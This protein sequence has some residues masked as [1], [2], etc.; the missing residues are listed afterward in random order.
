MSEP[1][2]HHIIPQMLLKNFCY[3]DKLC[4]YNKELKSYRHNQ[5]IKNVC[6]QSYYYGNDPNLEK[7]LAKEVED[8]ST[9][10]LEKFKV[11]PELI[12]PQDKENIAIFLTFQFLRTELAGNICAESLRSTL[13]SGIINYISDTQNIKSEE[14]KEAAEYVIKNGFKDFTYQIPRLEIITQLFAPKVI[15][16]VYN[17]IYEMNWMLLEAPYDYSFILGDNPIL[18]I[19]P[20]ETL[21]GF[22]NQDLILTLPLSSKLLLMADYKNKKTKKATMYPKYIKYFNAQ[23]IIHS[24]REVY[25]NATQYNMIQ[26]LIRECGENNI[27]FDYRDLVSPSTVEVKREK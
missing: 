19:V 8:P 23:S 17:R 26:H 2:K 13:E 14:E 25:F 24:S 1:K 7:F 16:L 15:S 9:N 4:V 6:V 20:N 21:K 27:V 10:S 11:N 18:L 3:E 22:D 12:S 5:D